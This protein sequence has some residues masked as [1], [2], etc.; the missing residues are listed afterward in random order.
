MIVS[1]GKNGEIRVLDEF[2]CT[3]IR[4]N[5]PKALSPGRGE[6]AGFRMAPTS[7]SP[8]CPSND[9]L[10]LLSTPQLC[11]LVKMKGSHLS[12]ETLQLINDIAIERLSSGQANPDQRAGALSKI[13]MEQAVA[14]IVA[15]A[16]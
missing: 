6:N 11:S 8:F 7:E 12:R 4:H 10:R 5:V 15:S 13:V 14:R 1:T 9:E 16:T 3:A 2:V